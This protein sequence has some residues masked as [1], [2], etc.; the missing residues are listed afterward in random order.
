MIRRSFVL[1]LLLLGCAK[2][3][4]LPSPFT[5]EWLSDAGT[6]IAAVEA[7]LRSTPKPPS[8]SAIVGVSDTSLIGTPIVGGSKWT[9]A[10]VADTVPSLAGELVIFT[11]RGKL[12]ALDV[13]DGKERWK[14]DADGLWLKGAGDDGTTSIA[15]L[16][17]TDGKRSVLLAISRSG[18]VQTRLE[19]KIA[20]GRPVARGG[21]AFVPWA[22][23]YVS[24]IDMKTGE[25]EGRLLTRELTSHGINAAGE[26]FF[27]EKAMLHFDE[28]VR[29]ASTHQG[30]RTT[31]P[32]RVLPGQP[33]WLGA[34]ATLPVMDPGATQKIRL[35]ATPAWD[36]KNTV[37]SSNQFAATY[38]RTVL[39]FDAKTGELR[40]ADALDN[41]VIGGGAA[42][43][44]FAL[45]TTSGKVALIDASGAVSQQIDLGATLR[46][47]AVE[48]S[49]FQVPRGTELSLAAQIDRALGELDP[50]MAAAQ[51]FLV[52]ELGR[53]QDPI[54]TK[55]LIQLSTSSR[56]GPDI[57][58]R[59]RELLAQRRAGA[60]F[61]LKALERSYDFLAGDLLPP[62]VGPLADA[63][64]AMNES[65]AAP[66]LARH[67][68]DPSTSA[69][70]VQRAAQALAVLAT[71]SE[72][73]SLKTFFAL[74]RAT[75]DEPELISAVISVARA[76][77]RV[78]G[79][80]ARSIVDRAARDPLT[81]P[82]VTRELQTLSA[83]SASAQAASGS[84]PR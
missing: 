15:S 25:E 56:I 11:A 7:S 60:E 28:Q 59:A 81:Q 45:C 19:T 24:A 41:P 6:S 69:A 52:N 68:N 9:Y 64:A 77:V 12:I 20:L 40:W 82:E 13:K 83:P 5:T 26:L 37:F 55:T 4:T 74:Y 32:A 76:M 34:G 78:G 35:Y 66:L 61:M 70:D 47:C 27:G 44:G 72:L 10:A 38:F 54:V 50:E 71:A 53:L 65:R 22:G 42:A 63:L 1:P 58:T 17:S 36:G 30:D 29:F 75:A 79:E 57:R 21:I 73:P 14:L 3:T 31:L 48:A 51:V 46:G 8:V 43:A 2:S 39:G 33:K 67:L 23:Q 16:G 84:K 49:T 18:S 80:D 62:P